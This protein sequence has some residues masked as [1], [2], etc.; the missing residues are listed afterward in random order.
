MLIS[1]QQQAKIG[2]AVSIEAG[3]EELQE[4]QELAGGAAP[5]QIP[6]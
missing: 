6:F 2:L 3:S 5:A 1:P 4:Q